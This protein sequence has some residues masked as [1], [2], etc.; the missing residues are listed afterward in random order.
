LRISNN[1]A[2]A[3]RGTLSLQVHLITI[4]SGFTI[5][6]I[7]LQVSP[8]AQ[9]VLI[10]LSAVAVGSVV[11]KKRAEMQKESPPTLTRTAQKWTRSLWQCIP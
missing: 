5:N 9:A 6:F 7:S 10:L 4:T 2:K 3:C 11:I 1:I 8:N